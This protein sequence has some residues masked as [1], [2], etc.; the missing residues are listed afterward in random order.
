MLEC[1]YRNRIKR[2][3]DVVGNIRHNGRTGA[4]SVARSIFSDDS[5][6]L[7]VSTISSVASCAQVDPVCSYHNVLLILIPLCLHRS[8]DI[9]KPP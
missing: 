4:I 9:D 2:L 1:W 8:L 7:L 3:G 6:S 5:L